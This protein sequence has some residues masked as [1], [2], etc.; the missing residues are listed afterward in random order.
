MRKYFL[1]ISLLQISLFSISQVADFTFQS[2]NGL[3][4]NPTT[5]SFSQ[6]CTGNPIGFIWNFGN[7]TKAYSGNVS[8]T[9][10]NVGSYTVKLTA[11]Y[12]QGNTAEISKVIVINPAIV[13]SIGYDRNYICTPGPINFSASSNGNQLTYTWD[14]G[15]LS[16]PV[17]S[18]TP[19]VPHTYTNFGVYTVNLKVTDTTGCSGVASTNVQLTKPAITVSV[20]P[21]SGCIPADVGFNG[22]VVVPANDFVTKYTW[23]F[24]DGSPISTGGNANINHQYTSI[25]TFNPTL[26]IATNDGCTNSYNIPAVAY[27]TPPTNHVAYPKKTVVCGSETPVFVSKAVNATNYYWDFGDGTTDF[28]TDTVTQHKYST[29]GFK[30]VNATPY[31]NGCPGTTISFQ[32]EVV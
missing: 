16:S 7:N 26:D 19:A 20:S 28:L 3:F 6:N 31:F 18:P 32:I 10:S 4:C 8:T 24:G 5:I 25:G 29:L 23:N 21:Q 12:P 14:F 17:N 30:T 2:D 13:A 22:S 27:G 11:I 15:D 9:Y 1:L